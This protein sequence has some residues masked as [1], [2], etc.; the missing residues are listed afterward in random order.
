MMSSSISR[1]A[2]A[3]AALLALAA[4][5]VAQAQISLSSDA[6][7]A[8]VKVTTWRDIPFRTVVRQQRDFSCGSA[9]LATLLTFHYGRPTS[10]PDAFK[11]MYAR[12]DQAKIQKSGFSMLDMKR[13]LEEVGLKSDGYRLSLDDIAKSGVPVIALI[14]LGA[15]RHFVVIK[16][17]TADKVLVGDPAMGLHIYTRKDF[18]KIWTG[19][20]FALHEQP[21]GARPRFNQINEWSPWSTA[22]MGMAADRRAIGDI[23]INQLILYQITPIRGAELAGMGGQ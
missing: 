9:A 10:E 23:T 22:P 16:G 5:P 18:L 12:G 3:A 11:A 20:V 1:L 2:V 13:Y 8:S 19:A 7:F 14:D 15:Y 4:S 21:G 6:D 17:M